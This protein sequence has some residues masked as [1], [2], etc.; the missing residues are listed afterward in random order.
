MLKGR[1]E[2]ARQGLCR[3]PLRRAGV[4]PIWHSQEQLMPTLHQLPRVSAHTGTRAGLFMSTQ[5][6]R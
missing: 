6:M 3:L 4:F 1:V 2:E 5:R